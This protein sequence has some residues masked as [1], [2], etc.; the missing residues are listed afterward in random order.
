MK[1]CG[2]V[3]RERT[4]TQIEWQIA[5]VLPRP[6]GVYFKCLRYVNILLNQCHT[7]MTRCDGLGGSNHAY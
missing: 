2:W 6:Y 7:N 4:L 5:K 1:F 3:L